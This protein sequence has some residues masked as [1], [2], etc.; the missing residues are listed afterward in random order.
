MERSDIPRE[1][2]PCLDILH[3]TC[4]DTEASEGKSFVRNEQPD[5]GVG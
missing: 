1:K 4:Q 2:E 5:K 3:E